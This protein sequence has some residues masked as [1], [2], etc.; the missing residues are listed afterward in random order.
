MS[1]KTIYEC[2]TMTTF[3]LKWATQPKNYLQHLT[4]KCRASRLK[5]IYDC[6]AHDQACYTA[7]NWC[8]TFYF[9]MQYLR[10]TGCP[11][12]RVT[13][14]S[15]CA[16]HVTTPLLSPLIQIEI[17]YDWQTHDLVC[18]EVSYTANKWRTTFYFRKQYLRYV[19]CREQLSIPISR[20][21]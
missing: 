15:D 19:G 16:F 12:L 3:A 4:F 17:I 11:K 9:R 8:T 21:A 13:F 1:Y 20:C 18:L 2:P 10:N 6:E 7:T 5:I 14:M